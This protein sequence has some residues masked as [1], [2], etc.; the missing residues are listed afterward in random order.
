MFL[1]SEEK[2]N[3]TIERDVVI[4][5]SVYSKMLSGSI[6]YIEI[7]VFGETTASDI[8]NELKLLKDSGA[9]GIVIDARNNGGGYLDSAV[10]ILS[11]FLENNLIAVATRGNEPQDNQTFFTKRR[12]VYLPKIPLV[13]LINPMSAS[14]TEIMAGALQD[15]ERA[16]VIGETSYGK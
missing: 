1:K 14:A 16:L 11:L 9:L 3:I 4:V 10:D 12:D 5:P 13:M 7:G 15:Y 2:R 8:Q 6:G